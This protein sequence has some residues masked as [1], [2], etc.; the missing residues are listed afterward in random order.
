MC[1]TLLKVIKDS[2]VISLHSTNVIEEEILSLFTSNQPFI[3]VFINFIPLNNH[4]TDN[5]RRV[6]S[7]MEFFTL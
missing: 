2:N 7:Y 3:M 4:R 6:N 1:V 5:F